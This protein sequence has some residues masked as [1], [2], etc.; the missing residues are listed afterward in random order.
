MV[1][2]RDNSGVHWNSG[3]TTVALNPLN[4]YPKGGGAEIYFQLS[5]MKPGTN[6][7]TRFDFFRADDDPK[8]PPRLA[9]S[10][11]QAAPEG[12]LEVSRTLGLQQ[13]DPGKYQVRL[14]VSGGGAETTA[15]AWL[16]IVK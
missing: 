9:V 10:S 6:Y 14:T 13:L 1:L 4:T 15:T 5:G 7:Q 11:A 16:T 12:R 8:H 3:T 2:G